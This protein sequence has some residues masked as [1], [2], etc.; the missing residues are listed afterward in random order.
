MQ[1]GD[2]LA[3]GGGDEDGFVG[4]AVYVFVQEF[5]EVS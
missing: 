4:C 5:W 3:A 2:C 1:L